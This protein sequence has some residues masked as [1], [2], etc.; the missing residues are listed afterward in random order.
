MCVEISALPPD[1]YSYYEVRNNIGGSARPEESLQRAPNVELAFIVL[2][3]GY[4]VYFNSLLAPMITHE[5]HI[6]LPSS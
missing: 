5:H 4:V 3:K 2:E 1:R 6:P